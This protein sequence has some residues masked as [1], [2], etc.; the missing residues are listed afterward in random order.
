MMKLKNAFLALLSLVLFFQV[1]SAQT[2]RLQVIHNSADAAASTVDIW[3]T[4]GMMAPVKLVDDLQFRNATPFINAPAGVAL[5]VGVAPGSSTMVTDTIKNFNLNLTANATYVAVANGIVSASGYSPAA[6]FGLDIYAMGREAASLPANTDV[7]VCHGSTDAPTVDV[8]EV[9]VG[10]GTIVDN[11][12]YQAFAGYLQLPTA[13]YALQVRTGEGNTTVAEYSAPLATLALNGAAA[14]VV[15][16]GFLNPAVNSNGPAFG[17]Y[18]ALPTGGA[19]VALPSAPISTARVQVIHNAADLAAATV[20]VWLN[21]TL[22]LD[23][24][25]FRTASP[26]IDAPAGAPFDIRIQGPTS[27]DTLNPIAKYTYTLTGGEKYIL[28]ANGIVSPTGYSPATPFD[29]LVKSGA[30]E[31]A[32]TSGNVDVLVLHGATDAPAVDIVETGVG[33]GILVPGATYSNFYGYL[34]LG[35]A[36]YALS[37]NAAGTSTT[38][39]TYQA[40]LATLGLANEAFTVLASGFLNPSAN[41]NGP[42]FGLWVALAAG[43]NLVELPLLT[44]TDAAMQNATVQLYPNP[45]TDLLHVQYSLKSPA[46]VG[47]TVRDLT[48]RTLVQQN[49]GRQGS[50]NH[51]I[52]VNVQALP[53]GTYL[54]ELRNDEQGLIQKINVVR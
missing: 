40:P 37:I 50:G 1:G 25:N 43:G 10:A 41:S 5:K 3:L 23:N 16:S 54:V 51:T 14:V 35:T 20:D 31:K 17:L 39:A 53:A 8:V 18:V 11:A 19:L 49:A 45:S 26:F 13:D 27:T 7:L 32:T 36:N 38:V 30:K 52:D 33:A 2:A 48:G 9:G 12:S 28:V 21:N 44:A 6:P 46:T 42:A 15:A 24:F 34:D 29:I 4:V 22:L 47:V